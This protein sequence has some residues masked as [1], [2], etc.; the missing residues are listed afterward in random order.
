MNASSHR[1]WSRAAMDSM[2]TQP[3]SSSMRAR[4]EASTSRS[5]NR[6]TAPVSR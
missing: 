3:G 6:I 1:Y 5:F 4:V 2:R